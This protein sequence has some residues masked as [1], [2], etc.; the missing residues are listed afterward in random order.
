[1]ENSE[2]EHEEEKI[3]GNA[4]YILPL[5]EAIRIQEALLPLGY[6]ILE[7]R[8]DSLYLADTIILY[9]KKRLIPLEISES[10]DI[11]SDFN[12]TSSIKNFDN[13]L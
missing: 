2:K 3:A 7:Y 11:L 1:M 8:Q 6:S 5:T 12:E 4:K 10:S 9:L 13:S